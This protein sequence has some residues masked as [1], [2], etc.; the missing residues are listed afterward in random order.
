[1]AV[2]PEEGKQGGEAVEWRSLILAYWVLSG[3]GDQ[4]AIFH[5][6]IGEDLKL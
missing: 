2:V 6:E 3:Y 5:S 4:K 1:M